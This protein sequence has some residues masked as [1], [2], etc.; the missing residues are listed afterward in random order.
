MNFL[1]SM[2]IKKIIQKW[3]NG[4]LLCNGVPGGC[5]QV[6]LC[7]GPSSSEGPQKH[8]LTIF[9]ECNTWIGTFGLGSEPQFEKHEQYEGWRSA[10]ATRKGASAWQQEREPT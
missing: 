2:F 3:L 4:K 10:E 6:S 5:F 7:W 8:D 1:S 9:P